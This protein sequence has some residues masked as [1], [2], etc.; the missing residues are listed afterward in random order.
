MI[1][2]K[3]RP[4]HGKWNA[5]KYKIL[6]TLIRLGRPATCATITNWS[7]MPTKSVW[8]NIWRYHQFNY[9]RVVGNS[10]PYYYR[11]T[12][13]GRRF[14]RKMRGLWLID[15][16]RLDDELRAHRIF[17]EQIDMEEFKARLAALIKSERESGASK[18]RN[19]GLI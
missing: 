10:R 13:K 7:G 8:R 18:Y 2:R 6:D 3:M 9:V 16:S 14:V 5:S 1:L 12:A 17:M 15:I 4:H 11:I 19:P